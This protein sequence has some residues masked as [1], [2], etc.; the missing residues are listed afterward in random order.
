VAIRHRDLAHA[1]AD[2]VDAQRLRPAMT[3][4]APMIAVYAR[5]EMGRA[6]LALGDAAGAQT[7]VAEAD[8]IRRIRPDLGTVLDRLDDLRARVAAAPLGRPGASTLTPAELR[9]LPYLSTHMPY[10]DIAL[11]IGVSRNTIKTHVGGIFAKL[12]VTGR[13]E[14]VERAREVGLLEG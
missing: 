3:Y 9:I 10:Q 5:I 12:E 4:A 8:G 6:Y 11:R 7:M 13:S 2:L 14:A 1:R